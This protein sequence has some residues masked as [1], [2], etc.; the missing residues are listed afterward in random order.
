L[1]L[2][3]RL[4]ASEGMPINPA[5]DRYIRDSQGYQLIEVMAG[6]SQA[7]VAFLFKSRFTPPDLIVSL[8][9]GFVKQLAVIWRQS[10]VDT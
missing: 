7:Q 2:L 6:K 10:R 3:T 4:R 8:M 1:Q 9:H 5:G